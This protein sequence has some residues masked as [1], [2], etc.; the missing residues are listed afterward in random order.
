[1]ANEFFRAYGP[2]M[3]LTLTPGAQGRMEVYVEGE[4]VFDKLE[5]GIYPDLARVRQMK[6]V[7]QSKLDAVLTPAD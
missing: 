3:G 1:M 4:K 7:I 5:E 6:K 2:D